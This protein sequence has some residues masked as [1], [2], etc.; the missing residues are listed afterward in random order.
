MKRLLLSLIAALALPTA[1][2]ADTLRDNYYKQEKREQ[3]ELRKCRWLLANSQRHSRHS[4][5][6][7]PFHYLTKLYNFDWENNTVLVFYQQ[8]VGIDRC[9]YHGKYKMG[10]TYKEGDTKKQ[11]IVEYS[12]KRGTLVKYSQYKDGYI[13]RSEEC[14]CI[15]R[16]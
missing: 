16:N 12:G 5:E 15:T 14:D 11:Y 1:V 13:A 4:G 9:G 2:N 10:K 7:P 6:R 8:N 3:E